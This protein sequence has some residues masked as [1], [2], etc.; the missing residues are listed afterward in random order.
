MTQI[1]NQNTEWTSGSS[2]ILSDTL[3]VAAGVTLKIDSGAVVSG[4]AI[5]VFGI[6]DAV[7][8][9]NQNVVFD[10]VSLSIVGAYGS[11][12]MMTIDNS[13]LKGGSFLAPSGN[14]SYGSLSLTNSIFRNVG[15]YAYLW[16]PTGDDIISGNLFDGFGGFSIGTSGPQVLISHNTFLNIDPR[17]AGATISSWAT[18]NNSQVIVDHN[19]F[20]D[21]GKPTL[22][23]PIGY[24][25]A[26]LT[27]AN[28]YFGTS[29]LA[30]IT[31]MI[32]DKSDN[33]NSPNFISISPILSNPDPT[34]P[35]WPLAPTIVAIGGADNVVSGQAGEAVISGSGE[36]GNTV[37]I[38]STGPF[39]TALGA[40]TIDDSGKWSYTLTSVNINSIGQGAGKFLQAIATDAKGN[41]SLPTTSASFT[42]DT[43][44]P[45][46]PRT[47][48]LLAISD[49]GVSGT[50]NLTDVAK[51]TLSGT[52]ENGATVV[53][54]DDGATIGTGKVNAGVWSITATTALTEGFN[55]ITASQTDMA[56]NISVASTAL[57]ITIDTTAPTVSTVIASPATADFDVGQVITLTLSMSEAVTVA[58]GAPTLLLN[59]GGTARYASGS[60]TSALTF[61]YTV[62]AGQN[63]ADL[64]VTGSA[65]NGATILDGAG[66]AVNLA[67][68]ITNPAGTLQI[69][70]TVAPPGTVKAHGSH[71]EYV[72]F[73]NNGSLALQDTISGRDGSQMLSPNS[74]IKFTDGTGVI[75][76]TGTA[77]DVDRLYSA[78]LGRAPDVGG[79]Q[80]WTSDVDDSHV[81]LSDIANSFAA[82][83]EFINHYGSLSNLAFVQQL[84]QNVLNRPGEAGGVHFWQDTLAAGTSRG[85][86]LLSF[87]EGPENQA[88]TLPTAGDKNNAE[89]YRLYQAA[90]DRTPDQGGLSFWSSALK[91][92]TTPDQVAQSFIGSPEFQQKYGSLS[93]SDFVSQLYLNVLHRAGDPGGQQFW[94]SQLQGGATQSSVLVGFS[95]SPENRSQ[96][97]SATH[98]GWVFIHA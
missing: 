17:Y 28:N 26:T 61:A 32:F 70:T 87:A 50:D 98:D 75:D 25:S 95:D 43:I 30:I 54:L 58:G 11:P 56:G 74:L 39:T 42:V 88:K 36:V 44:P 18:Y 19:N 52:G 41:P 13:I 78:A 48:D 67:G 51:P 46:A 23:L 89:A 40:A 71:D 53:L 96:T 15:G 16:Y 93:A 21:V 62:A 8:T 63:I 47:P 90:L 77:E 34:A 1:I 60:G 35:S 37:T 84:Y 68:A 79:L 85:T 31:N 7:G 2:H 20:L 14:G 92:G 94:T 6:L 10:N 57:N 55:A 80:F 22:A 65:L 3:Q 97:A 73:G 33:L 27:T 64:M 66:N 91:S 12:A 29:D 69:D 5:Q 82:S 24:T 38:T 45:P 59:D 81:S 86:V 4:G 72:L 83:P 49:S 9:A 76:P